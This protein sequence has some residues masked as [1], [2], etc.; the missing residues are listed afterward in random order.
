MSQRDKWELSVDTCLL[1]LKEILVN[2][3]NFHEENHVVVWHPVARLVLTNR[4]GALV[5][6]VNR[7]VS[8]NVLE[9]KQSKQLVML[10]TCS[11]PRVRQAAASVDRSFFRNT[12]TVDVQTNIS[13]K[14][15]EP[16]NEQVPMLNRRWNIRTRAKNIEGN[17]TFMFLL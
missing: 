9:W 4:A 8:C 2:V 5:K 16:Y 11:C 6:C 12:R 10:S 15:E 7:P 1:H 17:A 13:A 14:Y 3:I